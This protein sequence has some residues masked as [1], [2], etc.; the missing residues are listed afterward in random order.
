[1]FNVLNQVEERTPEVMV[2]DFKT[3]QF[4]NADSVVA[5]NRA[6][7]PVLTSVGGDDGGPPPAC[8]LLPP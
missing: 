4:S 6:N 8:T 3:W 5:Q 1:M 2:A 7:K